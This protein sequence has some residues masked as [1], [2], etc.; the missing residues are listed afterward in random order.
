MGSDE[1]MDCKHLEVFIKDV[2]DVYGDS[3][4]FSESRQRLKD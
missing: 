4:F 2:L 1:K 3:A